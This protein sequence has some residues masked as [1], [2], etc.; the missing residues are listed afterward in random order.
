MRPRSGLQ[1]VL[2]V[3][4]ECVLGS[5]DGL[6]DQERAGGHCLWAQDKGQRP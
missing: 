1:S 4:V 3:R 2:G 6:V 5:G